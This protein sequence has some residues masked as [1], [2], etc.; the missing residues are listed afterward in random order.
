MKMLTFTGKTTGHEQ[1]QE[2]DPLAALFYD[3][4]QIHRYR[5]HL[6]TLFYASADSALDRPRR[7]YAMPAPTDADAA[8][9]LKVS[10]EYRDMCDADRQ[11]LQTVIRVSE[12]APATATATDIAANAIAAIARHHLP[13][14]RIAATS[15]ELARLAIGRTR[16]GT[17][18]RREMRESAVRFT[19]AGLSDKDQQHA[20]NIMAGLTSYATDAAPL[21]NAIARLVRGRLRLP[22]VQHLL[23][24][25][26][27]FL[28]RW[29]SL[30]PADA[31]PNVSRWPKTDATDDAPE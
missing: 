31:R 22:D 27:Q 28:T 21:R 4:R 18:Q 11:I 24:I 6:M 9:I 17:D 1:P 29:A 13:Q 2:P 16:P 5:P 23:T 19:F 30:A 8:E 20:M 3:I 26:G 14:D 25:T 15:A 12:H 10:E 7:E